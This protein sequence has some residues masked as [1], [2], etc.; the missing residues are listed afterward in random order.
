MVQPSIVKS[1]KH[2]IMIETHFYR[3][4]S[5]RALFKII[6]GSQAKVWRLIL[7]FLL[8][9]Y[10]QFVVILAGVCHICA[11]LLENLSRY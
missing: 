4:Y 8:V 2:S 6:A 10:F 5:I 3:L 7:K 1:H 11:F 9:F